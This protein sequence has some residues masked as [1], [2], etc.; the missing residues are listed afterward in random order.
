MSCY[1]SRCGLVASVA[2]VVG[3]VVLGGGCIWQRQDRDLLARI[4][5]GL[6]GVKAI[7]D[8]APLCAVVVSEMDATVRKRGD[9]SKARSGYRVDYNDF[10]EQVRE[11]TQHL[12]VLKFAG[13]G[14]VLREAASII[15]SVKLS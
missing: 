5:E 15:E 11:F 1:D 3:Y 4:H 14:A 6:A 12:S 10:S 7:W 13:H 2:S 9:V 8:R